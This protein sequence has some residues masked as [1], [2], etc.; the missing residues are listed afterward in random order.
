[1]PNVNIDDIWVEDHFR[2]D[3]GDIEGLAKSIAELGLLQPIVV[4]PDNRL[5]CGRRRIEAF[6]SLGIF[7]IPAVVAKT[8]TDA[9]MFAMAE[10]DENQQRKDYSPSEK[11]RLADHLVAVFKPAAEEREKAGKKIEPSENFTEG[12][13]TERETATQAAKAVDWSRPTYEKAKKVI[14]SGD[15]EAIAQMDRTGKVNP[16]FNAIKAKGLLDSDRDAEDTSEW[17]RRELNLREGCEV[18]ETVVA[19]I[20]TDTHLIAWAIRTGKYVKVDRNTDWGN[21]FRIGDDG[22]RDDVIR[23]FAEYYLPHK[24]GLQAA[25]PSL[26]GKVLGCHCAP[27]GCHASVL[28]E[29]CNAMR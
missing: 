5:V 18:G 25:I 22:N 15:E 17:S 26:A 23:K 7:K 9:G 28:A 4:T 19:N 27:Q 3:M 29:I 16:A 13:R 11:V 20:K 24:D 21:P 14:A 8:I 12:S 2:E 10:R 6:K 1:M